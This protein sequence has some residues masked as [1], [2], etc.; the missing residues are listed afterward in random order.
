MISLPDGRVALG[1]DAFEL[2]LDAV[3]GF[4]DGSIGCASF[5]DPTEQTIFIEMMYFGG[6]LQYN[7]K[8]IIGVMFWFDIP[9]SKEVRDLENL[10][11][12]EIARV[13]ISKATGLIQFQLG[14]EPFEQ[15]DIEFGS[16]AN[17]QFV[18][19]AP[20]S[21]TTLSRR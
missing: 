15:F 10:Y 3:C 4:H 6:E 14:D 2:V 16:L 12:R 18:T 5:F 7:P 21:S 9:V 17:F 13:N 19:F 11:G 20:L 8:P 1:S